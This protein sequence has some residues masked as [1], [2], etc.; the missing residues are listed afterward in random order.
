ME[1]GVLAQSQRE[2]TMN[3]DENRTH[4]AYPSGDRHHVWNH[5]TDKL[6]SA[7]K[8]KTAADNKAARLSRGDR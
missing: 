5:K 6:V 8:T 3:K 2:S 4:T 7:H 1:P